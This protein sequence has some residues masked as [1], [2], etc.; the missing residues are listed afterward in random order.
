MALRVVPEPIADMVGY[1]R[2]MGADESGTAR[3]PGAARGGGAD[4]SRFWRT[5][6][7][8]DGDGDETASQHVENSV[9]TS[10][11]SPIFWHYFSTFE[12]FKAPEEID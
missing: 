1:S 6:C 9:W 12:R 8:D 3:G 7:Q 11:V 2:L 5:A 10:H 4:R